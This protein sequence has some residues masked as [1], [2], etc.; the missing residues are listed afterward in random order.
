M[1]FELSFHPIIL[2]FLMAFLI[3]LTLMVYG[4]RI[5]NSMTARLFAWYAAAIAIWQLTSVLE[6]ASL[7]ASAKLFWTSIKYLGSATAPVLG[8]LLALSATRRGHYLKKRWLTVPLWIWGISTIVVVFTNHWHHWYWVRT[9]L[10]PQGYDLNTDKNWWFGIYAAGM[11]ITILAST[12]MYLSY[13]RRA[14]AIYRKQAYWFAIGGFLPL[15]FQILSDFAGVVIIRGADQVIFLMLFTLIAYAVALFRYGAFRLMPVAYDQIVHDLASPVLVFDQNQLLL[16]ANTAATTFFQLNLE[17]DIG[18]PIEDITGVS[19]WAELDRREWWTAHASGHVCFQV[20]LNPLS[21]GATTYGYSLLLSEITQL[22]DTE[23]RLAASNRQ[24]QQMTADLAHD[25]RTP[26]Q[27]VSGYL[28]AL[29]DGMM[30]PTSERYQ[31]MQHQMGNLSKLVT[32]IMV[33]AKSDAGDLQL[34]LQAT[35]FVTIVQSVVRDFQATAQARSQMLSCLC[36]ESLPPVL[37]DGAR[38]E[39]ILQNIL[40]NA[41]TFT[42]ENGRIEVMLNAQQDGYIECQVKDTGIGIAPENQ[43][44]VFERAFRVSEAR[45]T[46]SSSNGLGLAI[47]KSLVDAQNGEI[48]VNSDGLGAGS[49]FWFRL[50]IVS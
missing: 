43:N 30:A 7:S 20:Q 40:R 44:L 21:D 47:C 11:Y 22:K 24:K 39:Q 5:R 50:P 37:A 42:P 41:I 1:S 14:P 8:L 10:N 23:A 18:K 4:F 17:A 38:V 27:I 28:E 32:D 9:Y 48:G 19:N 3:S 13:V 16:D 25:L 34:N 46:E 29:N 31:S 12:V 36:E 15:G 6:L 2:P 33:L 45:A 49:V 26:I 35:D